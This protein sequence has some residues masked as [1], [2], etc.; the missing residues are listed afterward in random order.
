MARPKKIFTL[1]RELETAVTALEERDDLLLTHRAIIQRHAERLKVLAKTRTR[2]T[3]RSVY[4]TPIVKLGE[5]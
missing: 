1:L 4:R 5:K 3:V 2:S